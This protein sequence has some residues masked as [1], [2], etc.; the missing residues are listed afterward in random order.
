MRLQ[1]ILSQRRL[2]LIC[3]PHLSDSCAQNGRLKDVCNVRRR[4]SPPMMFRTCEKGASQNVPWLEIT[5]EP[6]RLSSRRRSLV[7]QLGMVGHHS[8]ERQ[9]NEATVCDTSAG[10]A[11]PS[12]DIMSCRYHDTAD[13]I[14]KSPRINML[15][16][17]H[18]KRLI[19]PQSGVTPLKRKSSRVHQSIVRDL[20]HLYL[21]ISFTLGSFQIYAVRSRSLR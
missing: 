14:S 2:L 13:K 8:S 5:I 11:G 4:Q 21:D 17:L 18:A 16:P 1:G 15:T 7:R 20:Y 3:L 9:S 6:C 10:D 12:V 19:I